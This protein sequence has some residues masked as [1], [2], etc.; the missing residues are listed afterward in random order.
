MF[1]QNVTGVPEFC[2]VNKNEQAPNCQLIKMKAMNPNSQD[3]QAAAV[4]PSPSQQP[5]HG[6]LH[7]GLWD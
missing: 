4:P 1:G 3:E 6:W 5:Q 7:R 2:N